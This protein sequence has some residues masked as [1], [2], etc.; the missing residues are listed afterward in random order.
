L[1]LSGINPNGFSF[2][3]AGENG[4]G[5]MMNIFAAYLAGI[6]L[7]PLTLPY[8]PGRSFAF[9]G[10][11]AGMLVF[12]LMLFTGNTGNNY[13]EMSAWL[14]IM[15]AISSF[16][17]MNFTGSSTYTSLSGVKKEMKTAIPLQIGSSV[18]GLIL[19]IIGKIA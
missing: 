6:V 18:V 9:I 8:L 13:V 4:P 1:L 12:I 15:G 17:A 16:T 7:M 14:L 5:A 3:L 19:L 11:V 2:R 10:L